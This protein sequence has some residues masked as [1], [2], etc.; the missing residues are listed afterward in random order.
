VVAG[1]WHGLA[2]ESVE[3]G[4][5]ARHVTPLPNARP[6]VLGLVPWQ[7]EMIAVV[8]LAGWLTGR[9]SPRADG[10]LVVCRTP[11]GHR[12]ALRVEALGDVLPVAP[13]ALQAWQSPVD[14]SPIHLLSGDVGGQP[15]MLT[16]LGLEGLL[17]AVG[18]P[19]VVDA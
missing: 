8:D 5:S 3:Q 2:A 7:D 17:A 10:P 1:A 6:H 14:G 11:R 19:Q 15:G 18:E 16:V 13:A 12:F 4:L 9:A